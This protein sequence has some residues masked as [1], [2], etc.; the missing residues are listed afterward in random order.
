VANTVMHLEKGIEANVT[1][2]KHA[3]VVGVAWQ[4]LGQGSCQ[5][6]MSTG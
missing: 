5:I 4:L 2:G 1:D 3:V 6:M